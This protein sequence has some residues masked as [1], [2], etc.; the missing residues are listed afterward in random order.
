MPRAEIG[1]MGGSG[2]YD[3]EGLT[4]KKEVRLKTPFGIPS[5][6]FVLGTLAGRQVAF[7]ARH[8]LGHRIMPSEINFRANIWGMK[9]LGVERI[10]SVSA[11]GSLKEGIM[12]GDVVLIDQFFDHTRHRISTFFG[13]GIVAHVAFADPV[14]AELRQVLIKAGRDSDAN[15][16]DGGVYLCIEGPQFSARG[17]SLIYRQWGVD[18]IGMTNVTEAKLA[19]EAEICYA[20]IALVTDYDCWHHEMETVTVEAVLEILHRNVK[21]SQ[22]IIRNAVPKIPGARR[23]P[24]QSALCNAIITP[25]QFISQK[26]RAKLK[27]LLEKYL[28][29]GRDRRTIQ[30]GRR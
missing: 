19:R 8:G 13:N 29:P 4:R 9:K 21:L 16:H 26:N 22:R 25:P 3:M 15:V 24:C 5:G 17:E 2:L 10:I 12:P 7:L 23:C 30:S 27:P 18:V 1:I 11:V 14:C 20:T 28:P 6:V